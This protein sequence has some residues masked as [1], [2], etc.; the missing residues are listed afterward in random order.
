[1]RKIGIALAAL[2]TTLLAFS[3]TTPGHARSLSWVCE[4]K[5]GYHSLSAYTAI[6]GKDNENDCVFI[7]NSPE[8]KR[9]L[10]TCPKG[11]QCSVEAEVNN[12]SGENEI[13]KVVAVLRTGTS[14]PTEF[15]GTWCG[16]SSKGY[17]RPR[18][19]ECPDSSGEDIRDVTA[20]G[21]TIE[22]TECKA[23]SVVQDRQRH[24]IKFSCTN[25]GS[26]WTHGE[27]WRL[28]D[29][30]LVTKSRTEKGK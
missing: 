4:G 23:T 8:G 20:G 29:R 6:I 22:E 21:Y 5:I 24:I 1:M 28:V 16:N 30:K 13:Y 26:D 10:R 11:S 9:I 27:E 2:T 12:T 25:A 19:R 3:D 15:H 18:G 17:F 7:T 14:L